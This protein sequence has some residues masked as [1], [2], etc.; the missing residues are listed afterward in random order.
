[1]GNLGAFLLFILGIIIIIKGGDWF[2]ESA[3]WVAKVTGVPNV[4]IG[5]TIVSIATT[6]PELLVSSIATYQHHYDVAIGNV[7]GSMVCNIGL[8]LGLTALLSPIKIQPSRF[9]VKGFF[10][11]LCGIVLLF[12]AKDTIITSQEG[13]LFIILFFIYIVMNILEFKSTGR[14]NKEHY[15]V[16]SLSRNNVK[17]NIGKFII[18]ALFITGGARLLVNNGIIIA[19][20]VGVPQQVI[21]LTLIALGTSLPE[22][23]TAIGSVIKGHGEISVGNIL[24]ANILDIV[25][26][27]GVCSKLGEGGMVINYQNIMLGSTIHNVPQSLYLDIPVA[28]L[29][30]LILV[31]GGFLKGA[32][33]RTIGFSVLCIYI[34]Y[35]GILAKLFI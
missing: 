2:V 28:L 32:I 9:A 4:L 15:E 27:L 3:V 25:M 13:N 8:I 6:L 35:L 21:S 17:I 26:V 10:M 22:L 1:M 23:T 31:L 11:L 18:G 5:A 20:L 30:M 19:E 33:S 12:L 24:G 7:V 14:S 29:M 34:M 16:S